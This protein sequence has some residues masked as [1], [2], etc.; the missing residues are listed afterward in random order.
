MEG[1]CSSSTRPR[2]VLRS[3][4]T[5]FK[6]VRASRNC[7]FQKTSVISEDNESVYVREYL[8][9]DISKKT[10]HVYGSEIGFLELSNDEEGFVQL[11]EML[12]E[13]DCCVMEAT[14]AYH[15]RLAEFLYDHDRLVS[16]T[17]ALSIK[18]YGQ[19]KLKRNKTDKADAELI[20]SYA[21]DQG[22]ELWAPREAYLEQCRSYQAVIS[23]YLKQN[24]QLK[25]KLEFLEG[26]GEQTGMAVKSLKLQL[27]R[28]RNEIEKLEAEMEDLIKE[29]DSDLLSC[30]RTIPG[31]GKKTAMFLIAFTGGFERFEHSKQ[32]VSYLGLAPTEKQ[33]G[34]SVK[35]SNRISKSGNPKLR[36]MMFLCSFT[37][38]QH[39]PQCKAMYDRLV[40][41]GKTPKQALIAVANKLLKQVYAISQSRIPYDPEYRSVKPCG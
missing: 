12:Q 13:D 11:L 4:E 24:T 31:I 10:F 15:Y 33:S 7:S 8:G 26:K 30:I 32:L 19:M 34:T 14:G 2:S 6:W 25:N 21:N 38:Y 40:A 16:V 18:R 20:W 37:A 1:P 29:Y 17:N 39:N 28:V 35:G 3:R 22:V 36:S 23:L 41:K 27:K 5:D 9:I